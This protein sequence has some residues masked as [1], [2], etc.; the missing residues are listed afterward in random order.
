MFI[1]DGQITR[2]GVSADTVGLAR[3]SQEKVLPQVA[4]LH[5]DGAGG[6]IA[7]GKYNDGATANRILAPIM[8]SW[9]SGSCLAA[10]WN[11]G[12]DNA[13]GPFWILLLQ[14]LR[15]GQLR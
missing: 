15:D 13:K 11:V 2:G 8:V 5:F 10:I 4:H 7:A 3:P 1:R 14:R 9:G 6:N 12:Y